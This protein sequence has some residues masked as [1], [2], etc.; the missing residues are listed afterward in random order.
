MN[1]GP[2]IAFV[3]PAYNA[4][5][6]LA[7]TLRSVL[8]QSVTDLE[9][10]VVDDGSQDDPGA[11]VRDLDDRRARLWAQANRGL[12][13]ARNAGFAR[14]TAPVLCFLDADD[15]VVPCFAAVMLERLDGGGARP[16][17]HR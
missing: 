6:T 3:V 13:G 1:R 17:A 4:T 9:V 12:A 14:T 15:L 5:A 16:G 8:A 7:D 10:V 11:V 2:V